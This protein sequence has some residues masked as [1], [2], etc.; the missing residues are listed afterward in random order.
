MGPGQLFPIDSVLIA[1][2]QPAEPRLGRL[3][4]LERGRH[5]HLSLPVLAEPQL[6]LADA[7]KGV[8]VLSAW[9]TLR[10]RHHLAA[11]L[12]DDLWQ[13]S[14]APAPEDRADLGLQPRAEARQCGVWQ[15]RPAE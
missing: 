8:L 11:P 15:V 9:P 4:P 2:L 1:V 13:L 10:R 12:L 7:I 14:A 3:Q 6:E 5:L